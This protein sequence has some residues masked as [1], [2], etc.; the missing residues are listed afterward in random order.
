MT[1]IN[2]SAE[3]SK[4]QQ[5]VITRVINAPR[6]LIFRAWTEPERMMKW[7]GPKGFTTHS[8]KIDLRPGGIIR[9]CMRSPDGFEIWCAGIYREIVEPERIVSTS[10][11]TDKEGNQL[12]PTICGLGEDWPMET[13][14][15]VTL[16]DLKGKTKLTMRQ[17]GVPINLE[18]EGARQGW[19]ESFDRLAEFLSKKK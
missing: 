19:S 17:A 5:L 11:F 2:K 15:T 10:Y 13:T 18:R 9:F 16:E 12:P 7:W 14:I 1:T 4:A 8:C 3:Y 6:E